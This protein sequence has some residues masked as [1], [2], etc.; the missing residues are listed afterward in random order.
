LRRH[1][2]AEI[3]ADAELLLVEPLVFGRTEM[4]ETRITTSFSDRWRI[5]R[6]GE[7][8]FAE[9]FR[10]DGELPRGAAA[11]GTAGAAATLL[12]LAPNVESRRDE[13]RSLLGEDAG[14][15]A[16]H[17]KLVARMLAQDGFTLRKRLIPALERLVPK[18]SLPR[19]WSL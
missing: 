4:G 3:A 18:G 14:I 6:D 5:R 9:D 2:E 7:L 11:L 16:W 15:S 17:G 8:V 19:I 10:V 13:L 12:L 1:I